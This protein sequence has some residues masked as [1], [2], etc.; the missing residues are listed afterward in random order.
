MPNN[1]VSFAFYDVIEGS[2]DHFETLLRNLFESTL[3]AM[4]F[5]GKIKVKTDSFSDAMQNRFVSLI[6][7]D[8]SSR[9]ANELKNQFNSIFR[10]LKN[11]QDSLGISSTIIT[12]VVNR[13]NGKISVKKS[14][15]GGV[16][17]KIIFPVN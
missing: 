16:T 6:I 7:E 3:G 15:L 1:S 13:Y 2:I 9:P 14:A 8:S 4:A 12:T 5:K 10:D 11:E 17:I